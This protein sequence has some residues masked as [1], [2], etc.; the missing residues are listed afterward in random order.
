MHKNNGKSPHVFLNPKT[1]KPLKNVKRAFLGACK[2]AGIKIRFQD[3]RHTFASRLVQSGVDLINVKDLCGHS[4]VKVTER[5][6]HSNK[7]LKR[8]AVEILGKSQAKIDLKEANLLHNRVCYFLSCLIQK[9]SNK[10]L[11]N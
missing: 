3:L 10:G 1:G 2:R 7:D 9:P 5:Y 8:E 6:T 4:S 11:C